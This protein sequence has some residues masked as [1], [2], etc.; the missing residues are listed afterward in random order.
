MGERKTSMTSSHWGAYR[1]VTEDDR[2]VEMRPFEADPMPSAIGYSIP[3]ALHHRS[4]IAG[5]MIRR[6]WLDGGPGDAGGGRGRDEFVPVDWDRALDLAA[7]ELARVRGS[8]G[9]AAIF[10]GCYGWASAGRFHHAQSQIHRFLNCLG[11]YSYSV[12]SYST[13]AAQVI[14]PRVLG[15]KFLEMM[16]HQTTSWPIIADN[17][18]LLVMFG[19]ISVKNSQV[20]MGGVTRHGTG[21]WLQRCRDQGV[22]FVNISPLRSDSLASV[23]AEWL[24]IIPNADVAFM[25]ALAQVLEVE[26][27]ADSGFLDSH[28]RGY[29][30]F[31][32]YLLGQAD[33][34]AKTPE[35][36]EGICGIA[37][38]Q[39]RTLA[40]RMVAKRTLISVSW[41]LQRGD[42]G[43]QPY[44]MAVTLA[45]M[46]GQ[47]GLPGG[48]VGFGYGAIGG[49]G[50]PVKRLDGLALPQGRNPVE[51]YIPVARIADMLLGPGE[52]F[53]Y[54]GQRLSYPDIKLIYWCGGNPFHHHQDL[55]RLREAWQRPETIIVNEP[56]WTATAKH[57]DIVLP[58]TT[59]LERNDIGRAGS[60]PFMIAMP[61]IVAPVGAARSDYEIFSGLARRLEV[62]DAFTEGR[63]EGE[64]LEHLYSRFRQQVAEAG[65]TLPGFE[66][67]WQTGVLELPVEG[68]EHAI[69]SF[70]DFRDDPRAHPLATPSGRIEIFSETIAGFGYDDC[71]GHP[72]WLEPAEW[73]GAAEAGPGS[74]HLV[75]QQPATRLH[76]QLDCGKTSRESKVRGR[77]PV[78]INPEDARARDIAEGD[79][80]RLFNRRGA[81]LAGARLSADVRPGVVALATGAWLDL[82]DDDRPGRPLDSHGNPNVLTLD[83]GTSRLAQG[84]SA[85]TALVEMERFDA[86]PP[87]LAAHEPPAIAAE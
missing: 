38:E 70:A 7:G 48:G 19:G 8:H 35:W 63:S 67:F 40:R 84:S 87:A 85:H 56:W 43:E 77:E 33:G 51:R 32:R 45:A 11:G 4:R 86:E 78:L 81:C 30:P 42:H 83:K 37:A 76:S 2:I 44:W 6:G 13:A 3:E 39:T 34:I 52:P 60:D 71:P 14:I 50:N 61:R 54:N 17:T 75:S 22:E 1:V 27:L 82:R 46:L 62:A 21:A 26:S 12:N 73:L 16:W 53:D 18:E 59:T 25:L 55:N 57:A 65:L 68:P 31:R 47:I 72:T 79:L 64:W 10:G 28:C 66:E 49:I 58:A 69:V 5:P 23:E 74:L 9:N 36:A 29:E 24:P 15:V 20:S 80:V 41:S